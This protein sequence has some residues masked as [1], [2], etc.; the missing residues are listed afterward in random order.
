MLELALN[1]KN[2]CR[3]F[4][5]SSVASVGALSDPTIIEDLS[6]NPDDAGSL[7]YSQSKWVAE[8]VCAKFPGDVTILRIGQLCGDTI[9]GIWN[10][11]EGWPLMIRSFANGVGCLPALNEVF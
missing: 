11:A 6:E 7:G 5:C 8:E 10:E 3:T 9:H 4:F 1:A 2:H